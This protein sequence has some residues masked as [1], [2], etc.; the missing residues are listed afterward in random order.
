MK[1][2]VAREKALQALYQIDMSG[3]TTAEALT[4]VLEDEK[5]DRFLQ[6]LI[7]GTIEHLDE[8]DQKINKHLEN[9]SIERLAKVDLNILRIGIYEMIYSE[10][11]PANVVINE[12]VEIAKRFGDENSGK[13]ING[14]LSNIK[15]ET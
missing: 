11:A 15:D 8:I 3:A 1:R 2:R 12:A 14:I 9:W 13:F 6:K 7:E 5:N 10:D 4:F